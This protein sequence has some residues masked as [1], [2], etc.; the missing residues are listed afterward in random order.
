MLPVIP[1]LLLS[2]KP[3]H[4]LVIGGKSTNF[5]M[6]A[7]SG[8]SGGRV[9]SLKCIKKLQHRYCLNIT[10]D[11]L[12]SAYINAVSPEL[13]NPYEE[14]QHSLFQPSLVARVLPVTLSVTDGPRTMAGL[15]DRP[16][17]N[18]ESRRC[19]GQ[20]ARSHSAL[21]AVV[22]RKAHAERSKS[23]ALPNAI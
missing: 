8:G 9:L 12:H 6:T 22:G 20:T 15:P 23:R 10:A 18:Q 13:R 11:F 16:P 21:N 7:F 17:L 14:R 3:N 2:K 1:L 5:Q 4:P 19:L